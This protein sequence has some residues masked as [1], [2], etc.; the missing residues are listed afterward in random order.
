M[1]E[2][3]KS[4]VAVGLAI[5][6]ALVIGVGL[7]GGSADPVTEADRVDALSAAIKCPF[8]SGESLADSTSAVAADYRTLIAERVAAGFTDDE[9][10]AEFARNFGDG[11][12][13]DAST[14]RWSILLWLLPVVVAAT[15]LL[16]VVAMRRSARRASTRD[17]VHD[18][19]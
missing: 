6:F 16:A 17:R 19:V 9:I 7:A 2:Q 15:G 18:G 1:S 4:A 8:C 14:S 13:L 10:R 11:V 12:L 5:V 3:V